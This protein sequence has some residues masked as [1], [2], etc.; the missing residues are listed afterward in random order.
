LFGATAE[1]RSH[2]QTSLAGARRGGRGA[3]RFERL[4]I[5]ACRAAA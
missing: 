3:R 2:E 5:G 1:E 4:L